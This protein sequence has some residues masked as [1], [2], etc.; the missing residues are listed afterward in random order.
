M[1]LH[2]QLVALV[3]E[4]TVRVARAAFPKGNVYMRMR[5]RL[6]PIYDDRA[7]AP[8]FPA[9]GQPAE[10]PWRLALILVM[11]FAENL[12]D[13]QAADA[14]RGRI[15]WKYALALELSDS[16]FDFSVLSEFRD[17]L[18]TGA[19]EQQLLSAMLST[20]T[21]L[22]L[23]K[24]RGK[25]RTDS[26]HVLAA[27]RT[28]NRLESVAETLRAALNRVAQVAPDWLLTQITTEW[29]DRYGPRAEEYRLPKGEAPRKALAETIGAD[30]MKLLT[31]IYA[32]TAPA[33][34]RELPAVEILRQVWVHQYYTID[35]QLRW[36]LAEDLPPAGTRF[37]SPYDPEAR[38][39]NKRTTTWTGYKVHVTES[40]DAETPQL[41]THVETTPAQ[42][43]DVSLTEPI[44][45][46][47]AAEDL[48]PDVHAM[49]AGYVDANLLVQSKTQYQITLIGPVRPDTSWQAQ[50]K[51]G[52][53]VTHFR[54]D[55]QEQ[56]VTCPQSQTTQRWSPGQDQWGNQI[57]HVKFARKG[58]QACASRPLCTQAKTDPRELTLRPQAEHEA[59]QMARQQQQTPEW[60]AQY[61][62]RAGV[63]GTLSQGIRAFGLR[64]A[65][66]LGLAKTH[67]QHILTA[68]AMNLARF[69]AWVSG[70][71]RAKTRT[72]H[73]EALR[74][75]LAAAM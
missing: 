2:P 26:T 48:L 46:A 5:D 33:E 49:D 69:D 12:S 15:D 6:G 21:E 75:K 38:Y 9:C 25:Q 62:I 57:I 19:I 30:G 42:I 58:C 74:P 13:R 54:I 17:R 35:G 52:Y 65:R 63:E 29:F 64:Q 60:K 27:I 10:S 59:L 50:T 28:L 1:T 34:L 3:P 51:Q 37:D 66:Y 72:S 67:L 71:P 8:L 53:D 22:G 31:A 24:A 45:A 44:H 23:L 7:F 61:K 14:V 4:E 55:W 16:G 43:T 70:R 40:C 41:I 73:F 18:I 11:Q 68:A 32:P 36:R 20:F 47:L 39:G 56:Q